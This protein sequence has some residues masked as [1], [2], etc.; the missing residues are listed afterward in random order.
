MTYKLFISMLF[1][2]VI[3]SGCS[4]VDMNN[5]LKGNYYMETGDYEG[6]VESFQGAV[7]KSSES[8]V[9]HYYL[10][11]F[12]LAQDKPKEAFPHFQ[13]SVRFDKKNA[14]YYFWLGVT[15]GELD[16]SKAEKS[17]YIKA[18]KLRKKYPQANLY[19]GHLQLKEGELKEA[20]KSYD[21]VLDIVPTNP[22]ALYNRALILDI[23]GK[24]IPAKKAWLEYLK[25][26]PAGRHALQATDHLNALGDFS[27]ENHYLGNRTITLAEIKFL[28]SGARVS[29]TSRSSLR[30]VGTVVDNLDKGV[31]QVVVN[32]SKN[33]KLAQ[34]RS[35]E[36]KK[37]LHELVPGVAKSRIQVSW[38]GTPEKAVHEGQVYVKNES[39]QIFLTD[40]K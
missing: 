22:A 8:A 39:V 19:M 21:L 1:T 2:T 3:I 40:W 4:F 12:L 7:I 38:L 20:I 29:S 16:D 17:N 36:I 6:A 24:V 33:N 10:G 25:W 32:V 26:Y 37:T 9:G 30:L 23:E 27:Y 31:I 28:D 34:Q 5:S 18:L 11:R 35:L 13:Q 15:Y 14:D